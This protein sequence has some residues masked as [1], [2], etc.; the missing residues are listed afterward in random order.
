M[1][2]FALELYSCQFCNLNQ[3][4]NEMHFLCFC[5]KYESH[6][7]V[8]YNRITNIDPSFNQYDIFTK[9]CVLMKK[10]NFDVSKFIKAAWEVRKRALYSI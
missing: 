5:P 9:F 3:I 7:I 10:Y 1:V 4:E 2:S 8:L 6:R